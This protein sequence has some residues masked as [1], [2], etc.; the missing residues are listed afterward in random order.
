M[1]ADVQPISD[2]T[3]WN[4]HYFRLTTQINERDDDDDDCRVLVKCTALE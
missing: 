4:E 2:I 3:S 1:R